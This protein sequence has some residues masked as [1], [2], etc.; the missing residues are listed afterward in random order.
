MGHYLSEMGVS[1]V[2]PTNA[3][4]FDALGLQQKI[5]ERKEYKC[6]DGRTFG[7]KKEAIMHQVGLELEKKFGEDTIGGML[8]QAEWVI[9][10]LL[11]Y[12]AVNEG[13]PA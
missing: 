8:D 2:E 9:D 10:A 1:G 12:I 6:T 13:R 4:K 5:E 11:F 7:L 3:N